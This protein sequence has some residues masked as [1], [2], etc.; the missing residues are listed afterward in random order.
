MVR[1]LTKQ[2]TSK[3]PTH[4]GRRKLST[5]GVNK[6]GSDMKTVMMMRM[7]LCVRSTMRLLST[8][9]S[10]NWEENQHGHSLIH[11]ENDNFR[12]QQ[13]MC[14]KRRGKKDTWAQCNEYTDAEI[15]IHRNLPEKIGKTCQALNA[16]L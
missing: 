7:R 16:F 5:T 2:H 1:N 14:K 10:Q 6:I 4:Q 13:K 9:N 15:D 3:S 8:T 12:P 11:D